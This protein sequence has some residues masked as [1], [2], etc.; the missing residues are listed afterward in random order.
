MKLSHL[1][2][3][4]TYLPHPTERGGEKVGR[5]KIGACPTNGDRH[6]GQ[7]FRRVF[8]TQLNPSAK[9]LSKRCRDDQR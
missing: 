5:L 1:R 6:M 4:G 3:S 2:E 8:R 7:Q 9:Q